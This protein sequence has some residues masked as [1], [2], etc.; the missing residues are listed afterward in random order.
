[1]RQ[2]L[3][4]TRGD[5][6]WFMV[7]PLPLLAAPP[8]ARGSTRCLLLGRCRG[9]GS[10]ARAGI[11]PS[12]SRRSR[13]STRLPRTR[14]DRPQ[15]VQEGFDEFLAPPHARGST[16]GVAP[17]SPA[18]A[19]ID[20][21]PPH[22]RGSPAR[23]GIDPFPATPSWLPRT[24]GDR[25]VIEAVD[26]LVKTAPPHARG[27]TPDDVRAVHGTVGSPAR[28]GI[29]PR[30][31]GDT[32]RI[33]PGTIRLPRTRGDRPLIEAVDRLV[34]WA[35]PHA[36]GSTPCSRL[37]RRVY[38]G[39]P[40]RAGIDPSTGQRPQV[41]RGSPARAGI[42]RCSPSRGSAP[43]RLPRTRGDRPGPVVPSNEASMAPTHARGST[44]E[45]ARLLLRRLG[46]PACAGI[47]RDPGEH[48]VAATALLAPARARG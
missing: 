19:W 37:D 18:R 41:R 38:A 44:L 39:S 24:R 16:P 23:A 15:M 1:M 22:A 3:P 47:D 5:R 6:P 29:D 12:W 31:E 14:W 20:P 2:R 40:A 48:G 27:S 13:S 45:V 46:S 35:P 26:R 30:R 10:P 25:P 7:R 21:A 33:D 28:A 43:A 36:R 9:L 8:H 34:K 42:D 4:R 17:S 11:D 32:R